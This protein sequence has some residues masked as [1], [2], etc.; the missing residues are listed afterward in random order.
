MSQD[1]RVFL[2]GDAA[3]RFPPAGAFGMNTGIQ[4][5][6]PL[7]GNP[8]LYWASHEIDDER[9]SPSL[10]FPSLPFPSLPFPSLPFPSLPFPSLPFPSL[11]SLP[12]PFPSLPFPSLPFPSLP[13]PS[14]PF[15]SLPFPSLPF[16]S[17]P[18]PSEVTSSSVYC[19]Q[20]FALILKS[21]AASHRN[22]THVHLRQ[23]EPTRSHTLNYMT[24]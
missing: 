5:G 18:F 2:A 9:R 22:D 7:M 16:P 14:L 6:P 17:L 4:V 1:G 19:T 3:H 24:V 21:A 23:Q 10:P 15:P 11:P 13:F 12:L 20:P 8:V